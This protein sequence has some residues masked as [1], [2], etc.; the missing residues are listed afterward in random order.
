MKTYKFLV[1]LLLIIFNISV[2]KELIYTGKPL[3]IDVSNKV[4]NII[5]FPE[6]IQKVVS[7]NQKL[8]AKIQGKNVIV[9]LP[10]DEPADLVVITK[11]GKV[12]ALLLNPKIIP[13]QIVK[14]RNVKKKVKNIR[15][16]EKGRDYEETLVNILKSA[17]IGEID[18]FYNKQNIYKVIK[19][20]NF[21]V[22]VYKHYIGDK[23]GVL[24][25]FI[26]F[27]KT[28]PSEVVVS[29]VLSKFW[30]VVAITILDTGKFYAVVKEN[31]TPNFLNFRGFNYVK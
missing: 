17:V 1:L 30:N 26:S 4:S 29:T 24:E 25:G 19:F 31:L 15:K 14:I 6:D 2:A 11:G 20:Q 21:T 16:F 8:S 23:Y 18:N 28:M 13:T 3:L 9:L 10:T 12:Y 5:E 22:K 7:A 27:K